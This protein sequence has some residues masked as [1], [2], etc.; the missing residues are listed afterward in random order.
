MR[1]ERKVGNIQLS[2]NK[3][4][5]ELIQANIVKIKAFLGEG[6]PNNVTNTK[7]MDT[8]VRFFID[9]NMCTETEKEGRM[10]YNSWRKYI[11]PTLLLLV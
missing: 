11:L 1:K 2:G 10:M 3:E 8:L 7:L 4:D 6:N 9:K 5:I